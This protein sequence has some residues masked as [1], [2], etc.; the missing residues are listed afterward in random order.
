MILDPAPAPAG[1][2]D[3]ALLGHVSCV[4][5]NET[6]AER[7]TG[8]AVGD[9]ASAAEAARKLLA[10]GARS[11]VITL[12][13]KGAFWTGEGRSGFVPAVAVEAVNSTAAGDAFSGALACG[14][15]AGQPL[16]EA[17]S[18]ASLVARSP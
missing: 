9:E 13:S 17:V 7:L 1:P 10:G 15:A 11:A 2:L 4:K 6:E 18:Y 5:P 8:I 14:L 16:E 12:G 3:T